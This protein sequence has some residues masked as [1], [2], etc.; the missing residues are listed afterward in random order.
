MTISS[1]AQIFLRIKTRVLKAVSVTGTMLCT[2][3][4]WLDYCWLT[5]RAYTRIHIRTYTHTHAH[6]HACTLY[7]TQNIYNCLHCV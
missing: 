3:C 5:N 1:M 7:K 6:G 4:L 2:L